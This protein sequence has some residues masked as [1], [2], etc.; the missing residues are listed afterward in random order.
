MDAKLK[1]RTERKGV[2]EE[3]LGK[4]EASAEDE[5]ES[6]AAI[7]QKKKPAGSTW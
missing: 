4:A 6:R 3:F 7:R 1:M 5:E 2:V